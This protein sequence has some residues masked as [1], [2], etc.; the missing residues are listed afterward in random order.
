MIIPLIVLAAVTLG[1]A[2]H[3]HAVKKKDKGER[4]EK[5]AVCGPKPHPRF[6][7]DCKL[8]FSKDK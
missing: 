6:W 5:E 4:C 3:S 8:K 7:M 1:I 2:A